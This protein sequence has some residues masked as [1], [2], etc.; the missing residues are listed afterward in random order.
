MNLHIVSNLR[1]GDANGDGFIDLL[2]LIA[3]G[4]QFGIGLEVLAYVLFLTYE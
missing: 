3:L 4:T 1:H 2:D